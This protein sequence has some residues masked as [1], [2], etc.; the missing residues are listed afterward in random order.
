MT[1][2]PST[3]PCPPPMLPQVI[4]NDA[5]GRPAHPMGGSCQGIVGLLARHPNV[6]PKDCFETV[7][8]HASAS[9]FNLTAKPAL[10]GMLTKARPPG[11][12][13]LVVVLSNAS[14]SAPPM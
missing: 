7:D 8:A 5:C 9:A 10:L 13:S 12:A 4:L 11:M 3:C 14:F 6:P 2:Y 1:T